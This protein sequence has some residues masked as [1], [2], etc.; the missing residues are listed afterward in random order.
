MPLRA[1][2]LDVGNVLWNDEANDAMTF[3]HMREMLRSHGLELEDSEVADA[4]DEAV[5]EWAPSVNDHLLATFAPRAGLDLGHA[6]AEWALV[7]APEQDKLIG[8]T[9]LFPDVSASMARLKAA[10][11]K[12]AVATN[13]G[14]SVRLRLEALG[15]GGLI[16]V[17]GL[18]P[19]I[20]TRK[21]EP[22][23]FERVL[24][25]LAVAP[26]EAVMVGDRQDNDIAPAKRCGLWAVR[27]VHGLHKEQRP[28]SQ[29]G[30]PDFSAHTF[31]SATDWIL[32][33]A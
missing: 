3:Y 24:G 27:M 1:V 21:P 10:G 29:A 30:A 32:E 23:F 13:Y 9:V 8:R 17:W 26:S 2:L 20:G 18:A 25:R 6:R 15:F 16:D 12:L 31:A 5:R 11:L 19:E 14:P 33:H 7:F 28:R 4:V 22:V